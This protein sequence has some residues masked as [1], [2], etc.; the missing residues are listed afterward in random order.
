[1]NIIGKLRE[2]PWESNLS[3]Q[4]QFNDREQTQK[5]GL[6]LLLIVIS[7]LFFLFIVAFLMRSQYPDWQPLA[8]QANHPLFDRSQLWLNTLY[9]ILASFSIQFAKQSSKNADSANFRMALLAAGIF[10][11]AFVVGQLLF[12]QALQ[13]KGFWV[14]NNPA[15]S[16][17]YLFTG[18]HIAHV[19]A[20]IATWLMT[21][22]Y[23]FKKTTEQNQI[24]LQHYVALCATYWHFLLALWGLLFLLLVSKPETYNAIVE[25]CGL[26]AP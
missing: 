26:G 4:L 7:V 14:N 9:L 1:M 25:F 15:L 22:G 11:C 19:I 10:S 8:E 21:L 13:A 3:P 17:F 20:G 23:S 18:L 16:F 24:K 6:R 5:A 12:W 2:K